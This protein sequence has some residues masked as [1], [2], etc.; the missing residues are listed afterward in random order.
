MEHDRDGK[1]DVDIPS[2]GSV[3]MVGG[4]AGMVRWRRERKVRVMKPAKLASVILLSDSPSHQNA[5]VLALY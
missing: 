4:T 2:T 3:T 5:Q 1:L